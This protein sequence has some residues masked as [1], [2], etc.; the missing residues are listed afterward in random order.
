M[1]TLFIDFINSFH[2]C[3]KME[4]FFSSNKMEKCTQKLWWKAGSLTWP[5]AKKINTTETMPKAQKSMDAI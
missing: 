5:F 4:T 1:K 2:I 3:S